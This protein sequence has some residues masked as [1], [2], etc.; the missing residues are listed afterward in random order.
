MRALIIEDDPLQQSLLQDLLSQVGCGEV[1]VAGSAAEARRLA[2]TGEGP[3][4]ILLDMGLPDGDGLDLCRRFSAAPSLRGVPIIVVTAR[5]DEA[6]VE[7]VFAAG[8]SDYCAKPLRT[9]ELVARVRLALARRADGVR[10]ITRQANRTRETRRLEQLK[11]Q[12]ERELCIDP[13]TKVANRRH[14]S[15]LF[16]AEWRRGARDALPLS[17]I[18]V[19]LDHFHD[20]NERYGHLGG[21][22]C[23]VR[24]ADAMASTLRRPSDL[25]ARFGG[26]EFIALLP[27]TPAEGARAVAERLL[28]GVSALGIVHEGSTS[29]G[30]VTVSAGV[31]TLVPRPDL[32]PET[33][34]ASADEALYRAKARG[35]NCVDG[36]PLPA[37]RAAP[38]AP[39][40][41]WKDAPV[42]YVE[43]WLAPRIP[44][45][46]QRK[47]MEVQTLQEAL[48]LDA[49]D[50]VRVIG[51]NVKGV[52]AAYG[53]PA[54]SRLGSDLEEAGRRGDREIIERIIEDLSWYVEHVQVVYRKKTESA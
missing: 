2:R 13:L 8:A 1:L 26:E 38:R 25:L 17:L 10:S 18:I 51:H 49:M 53:F 41:E 33:L 54:L 22:D 16:R 24:V 11:Q 14:F 32:A 27:Q 44:A 21:D 40:V 29:G 3:D 19:D 5:T 9:R 23:L 46:L 7:E 31:A 20:F 12:L 42:A 6:L 15:A 43:P 39:A 47:R 37:D 50:R 34:L 30:V 28:L 48:R 45:F 36:V 52:G 35:R 4:V